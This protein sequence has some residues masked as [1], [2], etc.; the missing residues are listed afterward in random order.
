ME[1]DEFDIE[2]YRAELAEE[3]GASGGCMEI[4]EATAEQRSASKARRPFMNQLAALSSIFLGASTATAAGD[5]RDLS[6]RLPDAND[7]NESFGGLPNGTDPADVEI[8]NLI[9]DG[10]DLDEL[11][12]D[13]TA[14]EDVTVESLEEGKRGRAI[15]EAASDARVR[16]I[17]KALIRDG[18]RPRLGDADGS[19]ITVDGTVDRVL[20]IPFETD[21]DSA[22]AVLVWSTRD[23]IGPM[24][25]Y[26]ER[27]DESG[28]GT[29]DY[30]RYTAYSISNGRV[31]TAEGEIKNFLGCK[32]V[33]YNCVV[34]IAA[35][36]SLIVPACAPCAN[37]VVIFCPACI[38]AAVIAID[39]ASAGCRWCR[40]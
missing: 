20:T 11:N 35:R 31:S 38:G 33:N 29:N 9:P 7:S 28:D 22:E 26:I 13:T 19:E 34:Q 40:D 23:G 5:E 15:A 12:P 8:S 3:T 16:S 36:Y 24:G 2:Q 39:Y 17:K 10:V 30:L 25:L 27:F 14:L 1:S 37:L 18:Y 6:R 21:T 32:K 4:A